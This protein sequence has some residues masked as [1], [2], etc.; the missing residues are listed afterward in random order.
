MGQTCLL[1][2]PSVLLS[3]DCVRGFSALTVLKCI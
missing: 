2:A 1:L 3:V